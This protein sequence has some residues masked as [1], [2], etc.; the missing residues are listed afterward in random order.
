M[1]LLFITKWTSSA[2]VMFW[3]FLG[4]GKTPLSLFD[5]NYRALMYPYSYYKTSPI[6]KNHHPKHADAYN[7]SYIKSL[8]IRVNASIYNTP[9]GNYQTSIANA[10]QEK[11]KWLPLMRFLPHIQILFHFFLISGHSSWRPFPTWHGR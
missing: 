2:I 4:T 9:S 1:I 11:S 6:H 10:K 8:L 3:Y 7:I 5:N